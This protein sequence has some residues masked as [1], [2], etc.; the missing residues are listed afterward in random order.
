MQII[1]TNQK[2]DDEVSLEEQMKRDNNMEEKELKK[3][4]QKSIIGKHFEDADH[5]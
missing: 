1:R 2:A 5:I 4:D 3:L